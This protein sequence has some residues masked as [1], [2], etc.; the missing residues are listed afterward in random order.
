[1]LPE[2]EAVPPEPSA[3][4]ACGWGERESASQPNR[5]AIGFF[6][7]MDEGD[8]WVESVWSELSGGRRSLAPPVSRLGGWF[9]LVE[10]RCVAPQTSLTPDPGRPASLSPRAGDP[11]L[12]R[13]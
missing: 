2:W 1:M 10:Q 4:C 13:V 5:S 9:P 11:L 8:A 6:R 7:F 3:P 12:Q